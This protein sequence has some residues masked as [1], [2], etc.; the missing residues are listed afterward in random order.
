MDR[1]NATE[2]YTTECNA[3][4]YAIHLAIPNRTSQPQQ[5]K[6]TRKGSSSTQAP[7]TF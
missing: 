4:D 3:M 5:N 1:R 7:I 6:K 2:H